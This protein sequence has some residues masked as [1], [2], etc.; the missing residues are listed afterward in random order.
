MNSNIFEHVSPR[1]GIREQNRGGVSRPTRKLLT[2][3]SIF[4]MHA[5]PDARPDEFVPRAQIIIWVVPLEYETLR[6]VTLK[7]K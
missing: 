3:C 2:G 7:N 6:I 4:T 1:R 5:R